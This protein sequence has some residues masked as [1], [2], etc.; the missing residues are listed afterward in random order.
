MNNIKNNIM[1]ALVLLFLCCISGAICGLIFGLLSFGVA[2]DSSLGMFGD[3]KVKGATLIV[4][5]IPIAL[6]LR[7]RKKTLNQEDT[8]DH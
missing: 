4:F 5:L 3:S 1:A 2:S 6:L 7:K 8:P